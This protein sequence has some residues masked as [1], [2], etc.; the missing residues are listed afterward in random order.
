[1][2]IILGPD[3]KDAAYARPAVIVLRLAHIGIAQSMGTIHDRIM[4]S[5]Y[6]PLTAK[7]FQSQAKRPRRYSKARQVPGAAGRKRHGSHR[8]QIIGKYQFTTSPVVSL[9]QAGVIWNAV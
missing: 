7:S 6:T 5:N 1:M 8:S 2:E 3:A 4:A 9:H